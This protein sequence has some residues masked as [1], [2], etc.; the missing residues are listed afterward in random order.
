MAEPDIL[1]L[2]AEAQPDKLALILDD[3][4]LTYA[5]LNRRANRAAHGLRRLGMRPGDR[6]ASMSLNS[7]EGF[8]MAH[9]HRKTGVVG[10]PINFRL[11]AAEVAHVLNDSG[12]R[13]VFAGPDFVPVIEA[14]L[15]ALEARPVLVA[16]R[17]GG[18]SGWLDYGELLAAEPETNFERAGESGLGATMIYTSGTTGRP[19]GAF[20]RAGF[21]VEA[22]LEAIQVFGLTPEDV[23]LM[24]GPGYHSAVAFFGAL[25]SVLAATIAI[26]PRFD[27]ERALQVIERDRVSTTFMAPTLLR[28]IMDLPEAVRAGYDVSS[29]RALILGAAPCPFELK[30]RAV[31]YFGEVLWE[32]YG[33]TETGVNLVLRPEEQLSHPGSAGRPSPS[34]EVLLLDAEGHPVPEG[35]PGRLW[36]R[37]A[38]LAEYHNNPDA[39]Q[40]SMRDGFFSVGDIAYRDGDGYYHICDRAVDMIISGG[41]NIYPAE[42]EAGLAAHPAVRDVAVI[43]VPDDEWGEAVKAIVELQPGASVS[44]DDLIAWCRERLAGYKR[45]RSVDFVEALPRGLDGKL[46]KRELREKYWAG[47]GRRV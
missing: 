46:H 4:R 39:T 35:T 21:P 26:L 25:T 42:I 28:R 23:H 6:V 7:I 2:H 3:R 20:R 41:V 18:A 34:S 9:A 17:G 24:A 27:A 44:Q 12:A 36:V 15:P 45:P 33:A 8:E 14:A 32:F 43:G 29:L 40:A 16:Y 11:R 31:G 47:A 5:E 10:V 1:A 30:E 13:A 19:K 22:A 38:S 37:G